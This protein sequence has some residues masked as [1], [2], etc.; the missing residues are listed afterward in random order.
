[1][2]DP[3]DQ[4]QTSTAHIFGTKSSRTAV[5]Q[6]S[7]AYQIEPFPSPDVSLFLREVMTS[8]A[9]GCAGPGEGRKKEFFRRKAAGLMFPV[10]VQCGREI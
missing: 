7:K 2:F 6:G 4:C 5:Q 1:M 8:L 10:V 3:N 9:R